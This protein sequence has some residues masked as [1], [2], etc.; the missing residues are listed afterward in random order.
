MIGFVETREELL[1]APLDLLESASYFVVDVFVDIRAD[2]FF[3][4]ECVVFENFVADAKKTRYDFSPLVFHNIERVKMAQ[5]SLM[6][7]SRD[8]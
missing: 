6:A 4:V 3:D 8:R 5:S 1:S 7:M 2:N